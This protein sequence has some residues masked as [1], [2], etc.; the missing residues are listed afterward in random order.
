MR[1]YGSG[2]RTLR[3]AL[4]TAVTASA[5]P[6]GYTLVIS[7][8]AALLLRFNGL[9]STGDVFMFLAGGIGGFNILGLVAEEL[10]PG[11][12]PIERRQARVLAGILDW[13]AVGAAVGAVAVLAELHGWVSWLLGPLVA[14]VVYL[15]IAALQLAAVSDRGALRSMA[16]PGRAAGPTDHAEEMQ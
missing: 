2:G 5:A 8:S 3:A 4:A 9:P 11:T 13:I 7:G 14:T 16:T 12:K 15:L 10:L 6:Y 1:R